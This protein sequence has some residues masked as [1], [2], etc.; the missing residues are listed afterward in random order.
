MFSGDYYLL[1]ERTAIATGVEMT[2]LHRR[3]SYELLLCYVFICRVKEQLAHESHS[4]TIYSYSKYSFLNN[5]IC[6]LYFIYCLLLIVYLLLV[7]RFV[8]VFNNVFIYFIFDEFVIQSFY[9]I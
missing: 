5:K 7:K 4:L 6:F 9:C 3:Q 8:I 2:E 1:D